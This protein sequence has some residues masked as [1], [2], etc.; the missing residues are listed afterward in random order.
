M[1]TVDDIWDEFL[2]PNSKGTIIDLL[3][4]TR[5]EAAKEMQEQVVEWAKSRWD[6]EVKNRPDINIHKR[7]LNNTWEQVIREVPNLP[8]PGDN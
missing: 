2:E 6:A 5:C 3:R 7:T 1:K 4:R 8:L